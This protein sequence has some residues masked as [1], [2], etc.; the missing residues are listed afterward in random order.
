MRSTRFNAS[1]RRLLWELLGG[2]REFW[3]DERVVVDRHQ[4]AAERK[5][6]RNGH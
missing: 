3:Q 4:P 1:S 6:Y 5:A 2:T